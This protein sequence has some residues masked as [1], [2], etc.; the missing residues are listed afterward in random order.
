MQPIVN[1]LE[2]EF[3]ETVTFTYVNATTTE[4]QLQLRSYGLRGHPS[5][6]LITAEGEL[7]WSMTG[8]TASGTLRDQLTRLR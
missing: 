4:G 7:L 5:Y 8:Q 1:G 6:V 3:G 2:E